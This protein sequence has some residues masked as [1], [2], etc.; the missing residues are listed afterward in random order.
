M[1]PRGEKCTRCPPLTSTLDRRAAPRGAGRR[2]ARPADSNFVALGTAQ[3]SLPRRAGGAAR[4]VTQ[5]LARRRAGPCS[6]PPRPPAPRFQPD[7][8]CPAL[9]P[10][11]VL[12]G[13]AIEDTL[14]F[15]GSGRWR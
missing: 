2:R 9:Q 5:Q 12:G 8:R 14:L 1:R 4:A 11:P 3:S 7:P 6:L 13:S 10:P 15:L